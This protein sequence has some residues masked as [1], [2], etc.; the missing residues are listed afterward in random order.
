MSD[1]SIVSIIGSADNRYVQHLAAAFVSLLVN[2][3]PDWKARFYVADGELTRENREKLQ[4]TVERH[5]GS[6]EFLA[7]RKTLFDDLYIAQGRE[8]TQAAYYRL[9]VPEMLHEVPVQKAIYLDCDVIVL[10]DISK[11]LQTPLDGHPAGAVEDLGGGFRLADLNMPEGS[12]YFNSGVL[13]MDLPVWREQ[14]VADRVFRFL[15]ENRHRLHYHDQDGL[16]AVLQGNWKPLDPK[17]NVQRNMFGR[18]GLAG[19][20][21][22]LF[23]HAA[24]RPSIVHFT[25]KSKPWHFD[26]THPYKKKYYR[27][28]ALTEWKF[29]KPKSGPKMVMKRLVRTVVPNAVLLRL[30]KYIFR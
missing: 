11:L 12:A 30:R 26:N 8:I 16:N 23:R 17:W 6:I 24:H 13:L 9:V 27:Y 3:S 19:D 7:V 2:L 14:A 20:R 25:G 29:Y 5:G 4:R 18:T 28:L 10:D 22:S 1:W 15:R 21:K